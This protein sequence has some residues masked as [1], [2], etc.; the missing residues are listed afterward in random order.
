MKTTREILLTI[1]LLLN[2]TQTVKPQNFDWTVGNYGAVDGFAIA[3]DRNGNSFATG[4][5]TG[6]ANFWATIFTFIGSYDVYVTKYDNNG[7]CLW[8]TQAGGKNSDVA[9]GISTDGAGN[10][11]ITGMFRDTAEFGGTTLINAEHANFFIA[12]YDNAGN[13]SWAKQTSGTSAGA[14]A[15]GRGIAT[16]KNGNS[17]AT[18][19][20]S[21]TVSFGST[22]LTS[23]GGQDIFLAKYDNAGNCLWI[24][25]AGGIDTDDGEAI[26]IDNEGN[27]Y[28]VG[29]FS[30]TATF[31]TVTLTSSGYYDKYLAKYDNSGNC[32]WVK[33]VVGFS[34]VSNGVS[35]DANGNCYLTGYFQGTATFGAT[36]L[37]NNG[38]EEFFIAKYDNAGNC[39]WARQAGG[40]TSDDN[41]MGEAISTDANGNSYVSGN[42]LG[43]VT[44]GQTSLVS[45]G[46][47]DIFIAKY[48]NAGN[49]IWARQ[50]GGPYI[51][52]GKGISVSESG[53]VFVTGMYG[54]NT[55]FDG[56]DLNY[57]GGYVTKLSTATGVN[58]KT[59]QPTAFMLSQNYP[60][61][62]N[63]STVIN[64]QLAVSSYVT[65]KV[66]D[67][68]GNE[69]ATLVNE[70]KQAGKYDVEFNAKNLTS[71]IYFYQLKAGSYSATNKLILMK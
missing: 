18:G 6:T 41:I 17:Y 66:Y 51:D 62:F 7:N 25:Q 47:N 8:A 30:Y 69:A 31:G 3:A 71:G 26:S 23:F 12:K 10:C 64:Y 58:D 5:F 67:V 68:L 48:D 40:T 39:L 9:Y 57:W 50:A 46:I 49:F 34:G 61:P 19:W 37:T 44:F 32:L 15:Y 29:T 60:N 2:L 35:A 63:P 43:T 27:C 38:T 56:V 16:D 14:L 24:K 52:D 33:A 70:V 42:F 54:S 28:L 4:C 20:F 65:L 1:F 59:E 55:K 45:L 22:T 13:C 21:D 11:Y 53:G 36:T